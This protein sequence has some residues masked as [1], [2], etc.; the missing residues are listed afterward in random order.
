MNKPCRVQS[1]VC[2]TIR[3]MCKT[4][5]FSLHLKGRMAYPMQRVATDILGPLAETQSGNSYVLVVA[6]YFTRWVEAFVIPNQEATTVARKLVNE[7]FCHFSPPEQLHSDQS[8][9]FESLLLAEV[10]RLLGIKK[11]TND[12]LPPPVG[13]VG[14]EMKSNTPTQPINVCE[15]SSRIL[16]RLCETNLH[17]L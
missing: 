1:N 5:M 9:Q 6:D 3:N 12:S 8:H 16:G 17:G 15:R 14:G 2:E 10:C 7:V 4:R 13:W 11:N